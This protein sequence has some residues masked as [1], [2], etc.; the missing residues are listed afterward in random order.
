MREIA[1]IEE[2]GLPRRLIPPGAS[3]AT[4]WDHAARAYRRS[5]QTRI[6]IISSSVAMSNSGLDSV[7][8]SLSRTDCR[9]LNSLS[10]MPWSYAHR[11]KD[12]SMLRPSPSMVRTSESFAQFERGVAPDN[13]AFALD[14]RHFAD[15]F[16]IYTQHNSLPEW[17]DCSESTNCAVR[18]ADGNWPSDAS[19]G[20]PRSRRVNCTL[21]ASKA[22]RLSCQQAY[23]PA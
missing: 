7:C 18:D 21:V 2:F 5:A 9:G 3:G 20:S 8:S 10:R 12:T 22:K 17:F 1:G 11:C 19:Y 6:A 23:C 13:S 16:N 14:D 4:R 15:I